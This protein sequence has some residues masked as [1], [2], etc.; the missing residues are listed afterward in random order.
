MN[1][2]N[3]GTSNLPTVCITRDAM[4]KM[5]NQWIVPIWCWGH[6]VPHESETKIR[7]PCDLVYTITSSCNSTWLQKQCKQSS[8]HAWHW[9]ASRSN[10]PSPLQ[11]HSCPLW[12]ILIH[13]WIIAHSLTA[14]EDRNFSRVVDLRSPPASFCGW[15]RLPQ[16]HREHYAPM[17]LFYWW[18]IESKHFWHGARGVCPPIHQHVIASKCVLTFSCWSLSSNRV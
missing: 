18:Q 8:S 4:C 15:G 2:Q 6:K 1:N 7:A 13:S 16:F 14:G 9:Q 10:C 12:R 17:W 5:V 3:S 11:L